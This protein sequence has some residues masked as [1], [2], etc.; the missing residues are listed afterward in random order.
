M[1][2]GNVREGGRGRNGRARGQKVWA[3]LIHQVGFGGQPC[4][5]ALLLLAVLGFTRLQT[6]A[7]AVALLALLTGLIWPSLANFG[8]FSMIVGLWWPDSRPP[9]DPPK[10]ETMQCSIGG[11]G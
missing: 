8:Y 4:L 3:K 11:G 6:P 9:A 5:P 1:N 2:A 7:E 10:A